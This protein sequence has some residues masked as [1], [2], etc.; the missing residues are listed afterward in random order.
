MF[1]SE[2]MDNLWN[3]RS[4]FSTDNAREKTSAVLHDN[5]RL[6]SDGVDRY[7]LEKLW[8]SP[9][10]DGARKT[11]RVYCERRGIVEDSVN[12][13]PSYTEISM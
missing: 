2:K 4:E 9:T 1:F 11:D 8:R 5:E 3:Q 6:E 10:R 12:G 7:C 13:N